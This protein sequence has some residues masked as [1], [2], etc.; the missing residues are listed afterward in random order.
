MAK[1]GEVIHST[2]GLKDSSITISLV[3]PDVADVIQE[4]AL[5]ASAQAPTLGSSLSEVYAACT[6]YIYQDDD[7]HDTCSLTACLNPLHPGPCKGWKGTLHSV[8]PAAWHT[9]EAARVEKANHNRIKKIEA[10]KAQGKPIPHKLL[11]PILPKANPNVG[12]TANKATGEAH[13]AGQAVSD[14]AGI[15]TSTPG[16]VTLGQAIKSTPPAPVVKGPKGKKPT[17]ASHGIAFVIAQEKV[18][19][20][21]KLDKAAKIT[22]EQWSALSEADQSTIRGEL[23]KIK[24]DGF[25]P[26]QKKADELLAKLSPEVKQ[27]KQAKGAGPSVPPPAPHHVP[28]SP[29]QPLSTKNYTPAMADATDAAGNYANPPKIHALQ[30]TSADRFKAY[31]KLNA[32]EWKA[33]PDGTK[34]AIVKDM[35]GQS[36]GDKQLHQGFIDENGKAFTPVSAWLTRRNIEIPKLEQ[37]KIDKFVPQFAKDKPVKPAVKV[38]IPEKTTVSVLNKFGTDSHVTAVHHPKYG[39]VSKATGDHPAHHEAN[40][41]EVAKTVPEPAPTKLSEIATPKTPVTTGGKLGTAQATTEMTPLAFTKVIHKQGGADLIIGGKQITV[42]FAGQGKEGTLTFVPGLGTGTGHYVVT[43]KD[44][45]KYHFGKGEHVTV[46]PQTKATFDDAPSA[47]VPEAAAKPLP[48]HVTDAIAM[49]KGQAPG[50]SWSKNHLAAYQ[51]LTAEEFHAL[52]KDVQDTI[53]S[54]LT[55]GQSKFLDP[56]KITAAKDLLVKFGHGETK[57]PEAP[58]V[59]VGFATHLHDHSVTDAQA[60]QVVAQQ[61]VAAQAKVVSAVTGVKNTDMPESSWH[62]VKASQDAEK[63]VEMQTGHHPDPDGKI[64]NDPQVKAAVEH[65]GKTAHDLKYAQSVKKANEGVFNQMALKLA[66]DNGE[67]SPIEKATL[68]AY[69]KHLLDQEITQAHIDKLQQATVTAIGDLSDKLKAAT[70]KGNAPAPEDMSNAQIADRAKEL[71]GPDAADVQINLSPEKLAYTNGMAQKA[72]EKAANGV[73]EEILT[74]PAVAGPYQAYATALAQQYATMAMQGTLNYHLKV[75]HQDALN[76]GYSDLGPLSAADKQVIEKHADILKQ[77]F[78]Y[79]DDGLAKQTAAAAQAHAK[80]LDAVDKA[81]NPPEPVKL[82]DY[83]KTTIPDAYTVAWYAAAKKAVTFGAQ[84]YS[85]TSAKM[86]A[87][88]EYEGLTKDLGNLKALAG[89]VALAHAEENTAH[90]NVPLD[91]DTGNLMT[92]PELKAW[93]AAVAH[94]KETEAEFA[95]LHKQAQAKLDT[96]RTAAGL[97]KR[98][99]PKIDA[100]AVKTLAAEKAY[101]TTSGYSG[102]NY[103]KPSSAKQYL[104][105]K[106][107]PALAV[108]HQ[109]P[110]EKKLGKLG[111]STAP[112]TSKI[113][114]V[115]PSEPVKLGDVGSSSISTVPAALKKQITSD[116]KA[117][118]NGK[119]LSDPAEDIFGNLVNLAAAHGKTIPGG[120]SIDQ[121]LKTIDE[122]HS[123]SLG[124]ANSGMLHKKITDWLGTATGKAYAEAHST[125]DTKKVKQLTGEIDLP[126][127]VTLAPGEKVQKLA[128]P[129]PHDPTLDSTAFKALNAH[130]AQNA[131]DAYMKA[132]GTKWSAQQKSA[133]KSYTGSAYTTYNNFLRGG[134][135]NQATKQAVVTIQ[136]AMMPLPQHTLLKRGTGWPPELAAFKSNPE[137]LLGKTFEEPGFTSTTV[138]GSGGHFSGQPLQLVIEAPKGSPAAFI[139]GISHFKGQENEMLLAAG[140][141][142][143]VLSVDKTS[144]GHTLV[145]VRIVGDK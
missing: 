6:G 132:S 88:N 53:V 41:P 33:L 113:K 59:P 119:Y 91:P 114:N 50:A 52:P 49:A 58:K 63:L 29:G 23:A 144:G 42:G 125:P 123:K 57:K 54:E 25:G 60:K 79:L 27:A 96:I 130:Q 109:T 97:K 19:P 39:E 35:I 78:A 3:T 28:K 65:L 93:N 21:Y 64:L 111:G 62:Q 122:T 90:L 128:G 77:K 44:G 121:V 17:L 92:G 70:K 133:I 51:P 117:M 87:H 31:G 145:R 107:G 8:S 67:L 137:K 83:D 40:P 14:A 89:K 5:L 85:T 127:G 142:F 47:K 105:A 43:T 82:S 38:A 103:G 4:V 22:P 134:T 139:N 136:S 140:T 56:K 15:K 94:R 61:P 112:T 124:V 135:G 37:N 13:T 26:Q 74:S 48:K 110:A 101:Y 72:A 46:V 69:G 98:A 99:L 84:P 18:T 102:P 86:K 12:Q 10:L 81:Q 73:S 11:Q 141:K 34:T 120:L 71:L 75:L 118:P 2:G 9:L 116:F 143:K 95:A 108:A 30:M 76:T 45:E 20:Q 24:I 100:P 80:F 16:K 126:K 115:V 131:Q 138:A 68:N 7:A 55:K 66:N 106:V 129:G 104:A 32:E 1:L 36:A